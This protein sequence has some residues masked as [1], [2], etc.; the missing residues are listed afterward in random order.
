[1]IF[2]TS[3]RFKGINWSEQ[4]NSRYIWMAESYEATYLVKMMGLSGWLGNRSIRI[5]MKNGA[6]HQIFT[7]PGFTPFYFIKSGLCFIASHIRG[8][9]NVYPPVYLREGCS[10]HNI[11]WYKYSP[12]AS[13]RNMPRNTE[14][15]EI[16]GLE[17]VQCHSIRAV[18]I[19]YSFCHFIKELP[20]VAKTKHA[21]DF[22][23]PLQSIT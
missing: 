3:S 10:V 13:S 7:F 16:G 15:P 4:V 20:Q 18:A 5:P 1:M 12:Q 2:Q 11:M 9:T 21:M 22:L 6:A 23:K 8:Q 19:A 17:S 14:Y